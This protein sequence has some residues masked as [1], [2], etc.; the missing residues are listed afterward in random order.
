[1]PKKDTYMTGSAQPRQPRV[2]RVEASMWLATLARRFADD[3]ASAREVAQAFS[4][5]QATLPARPDHKVDVPESTEA[6]IAKGAAEGVI[7]FMRSE[8]KQPGEL[9]CVCCPGEP[10]HIYRRFVEFGPFKD[11]Y[12]AHFGHG[13]NELLGTVALNNNRFDGKR[14]RVTVEVL[15]D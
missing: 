8:K 7:R 15:E 11:V 6:V 3:R 4:D 14:V 5:W 1:L 13:V 9:K 12:P 2:P 10:G